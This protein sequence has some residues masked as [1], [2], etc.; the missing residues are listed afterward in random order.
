[1][2]ATSCNAPDRKIPWSTTTARVRS[3]TAS[4]H[5]SRGTEMPSG[6]AS[7][8]SSTPSGACARAAYRREGK[9]SSV[10]TTFRRAFRGTKLPSR[11]PKRVE[12]FWCSTTEPGGAWRRAA[13]R[14]ACS[15]RYGSHS[16]HASTPFSP[17]AWAYRSSQ[18]RAD[19][20]MAPMEWDTRYVT[21]S[22]MGN[23]GRHRS[24]GVGHGCRST[25][26]LASHSSG[27]NF[28]VRVSL[29]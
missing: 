13:T 28:L 29:K 7:S 12:T 16:S 17:H 23:S 10:A 5:A 20:G 9:F 27:K 6:L 8:C 3:S 21:R 1:M 11:S 2:A 26:V 14:F 22:R 4:S 24:R 18:V 25:K 15:R 19:R